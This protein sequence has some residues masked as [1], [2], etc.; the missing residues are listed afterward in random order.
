M[1]DLVERLLDEADL[2]ANDGAQDIADLLSEAARFIAATKGDLLRCARCIEDLKQP[3]SMGDPES[4]VA[5]RNSRYMN[6][7]AILRQRAA[8][9][10]ASLPLTS[11]KTNGK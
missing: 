6:I 9:I 4:P 1:A 7:A 3:V 5:I 8:E 10:P 2:C 11:K